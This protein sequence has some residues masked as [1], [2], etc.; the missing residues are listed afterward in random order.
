MA[1]ASIIL[2]YSFGQNW[3]LLQV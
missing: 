1:E 3:R 2:Q